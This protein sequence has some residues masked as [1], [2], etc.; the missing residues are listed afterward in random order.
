M[1]CVTGSTVGGHTSA[2]EQ[3]HSPQPFLSSLFLARR[4]RVPRKRQTPRQTE[5]E[6]RA[7]LEEYA[8]HT[9]DFDHLV[10]PPLE[11]AAEATL[12]GLGVSTYADW[13][14]RK[15]RGRP[16]AAR[17][18]LSEEWFAWEILL[19][20]DK[21]RRCSTGGLHD[22]ALRLSGRAQ[23]L[24]AKVGQRSGGSKGGS[25]GSEKIQRLRRQVAKEYRDLAPRVGDDHRTILV[26]ARKHKRHERTIRRYIEIE[27]AQNL[28][29]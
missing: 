12:E 20:L 22:M 11:E 21:A 25:A 28:G 13:K 3:G 23:V 29:Q 8:R 7:V 9:Y 6:M 17:K 15:A 5:A 24:A 1:R 14:R 2:L 18:K 26:L 19:T 16:N 4:S 10:A 27:A